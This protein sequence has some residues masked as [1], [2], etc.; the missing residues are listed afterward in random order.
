[1]AEAV[2]TS[3]DMRVEG[4]RWAG[5][6]PAGAGALAPL[7]LRGIHKCW[8]GSEPVLAG[9]DLEL[10]PGSVLAI[11]GRNGAGKTTLLRIACGLIRPDAGTVRADGFDP[12][13]DSTEF[14]RRV[15]LVSAGNSGLY[16][17]LRPEHHLDLWSRLALMPRK[18]REPAIARVAAQFD[19]EPLYGKRVDR[20]SM[21]QRQR[22]RL[23]LA[24]LHDPTV[25]MLDEPSNSLDGEAIAL[26]ADALDAL[27]RRGGAAIVCLPSGWSSALPVDADMVLAQGRLEPA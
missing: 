26:L 25:V 6:S 11:S 27:R 4:E 22:L 15:G 16:A 12:E 21:G 8:P 20:L 7:S 2:G 1:M 5:A 9:V 13:A 18:V 24:F 14:Q 23:A 19:L 3:T 17:R 10:E